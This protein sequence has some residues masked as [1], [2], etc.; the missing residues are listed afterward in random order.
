M[1]ILIGLVALCIAGF[2][3]LASAAIAA[4]ETS[5]PG[6]ALFEIH[7][8]GCHPQGGNIIR[9]GKTL[10]QRALARNKADSPEAIA[11]I[12]RNGKG[13]MSA[14]G[15]RLSAPEITPLAQY[16]WQQAQAD[17]P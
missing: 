11:A 7:C 16:V 1:R 8:V 10:K 9:R 17:W 5:T 12:I 3:G 2:L 4:P 6:A 13:I 15:D 14:Y